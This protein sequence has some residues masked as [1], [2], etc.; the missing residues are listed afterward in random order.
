MTSIHSPLEGRPAT[1]FPATPEAASSVPCP[2]SFYCRTECGGLRTQLFPLASSLNNGDVRKAGE[3]LKS[4]EN[5]N[6]VLSQPVGKHSLKPL[7][8]KS[9]VAFPEGRVSVH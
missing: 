8:K 1:A 9:C 3:T 6:K 5:G 2:F 7:S 4:M